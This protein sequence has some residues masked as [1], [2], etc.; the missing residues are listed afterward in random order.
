VKKRILIID[1]DEEMCEELS[2]ILTDE[3]YA[4]SSVHNG[5]EGRNRIAN[6]GYDVILLD[7]KLPGL[8]GYDI[9]KSSATVHRKCKIFVLTG[10]PMNKDFESGNK[11]CGN[12]E[13]DTLKLADGVINKPFDIQKVL[14]TIKQ[15]V[16]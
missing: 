12:D 4:V 15:S 16:N 5:L 7:I 1:D 10:R 6:N 8:T 3:G 9:L 2:E 11:S 13:E 14:E